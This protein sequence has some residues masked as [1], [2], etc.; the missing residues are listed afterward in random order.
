M[1]VN[2]HS[3]VTQLGSSVQ[4]DAFQKQQALP[5]RLSLQSSSSVFCDISGNG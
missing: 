4:S 3:V 5:Q 1:A 2:I